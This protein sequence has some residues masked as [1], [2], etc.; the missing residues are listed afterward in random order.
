MLVALGLASDLSVSSHRDLALIH[1]HGSRLGVGFISFVSSRLIPWTLLSHWLFYSHIG[2]PIKQSLLTLMFYRHLQFETW[3]S[4]SAYSFLCRS[5]IFPSLA[6][7]ALKSTGWPSH[8]VLL[9]SPFLLL[10]FLY[11]ER[12]PESF[13]GA[14]DNSKF[15]ILCSIG[16]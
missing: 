2:C 1:A 7:H 11:L 8:P 15:M 12:P 6:F 5:S 14:V 10:T 4:V 13:F 3:S 16:F 9:T